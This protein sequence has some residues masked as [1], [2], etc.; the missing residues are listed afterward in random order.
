MQ[1]PNKT[2]HF[3]CKIQIHQPL[4]FFSNATFSKPIIF[5]LAFK[6]ANLLYGLMHNKYIITRSS[7]RQIFNYHHNMPYFLCRNCNKVQIK[8]RIIAVT[9]FSKTPIMIFL[10]N[11]LFHFRIVKGIIIIIYFK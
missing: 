7:N 11:K 4:S 1:S 8:I 3:R 2:I 5:P 6:L 9:F 10:I